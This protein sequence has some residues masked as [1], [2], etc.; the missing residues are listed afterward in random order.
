MAVAV[1]VVPG[2][3]AAKDHCRKILLTGNAGINPKPVIFYVKNNLGDTTLSE[4]CPVTAQINEADIAYIKR[5]PYAWGTGPAACPPELQPGELPYDPADPLKSRCIDYAG[6]SCR[7]KSKVAPKTT[8]A[9]KKYTEI[10]CFEEP[11]CGVKLG[12]SSPTPIP[13]TIQVEKLGSGV[14][15][16]DPNDCDDCDTCVVDPDP[17]GARQ[18]P[19]PAGARCRAGLA[20]AVNSYIVGT[21]QLLVD[22]H[23][24]RMAGKR[25]PA[26][27]CNTTNADSEI[28]TAVNALADGI[29]SAAGACTAARSPAT[30]GFR[31]CPVPCSGIGAAAC[32][33]GQV[34]LQCQ[35][36]R[37]C[38]VT[39][40]AGD[41][42]CGDWAQATDCIACL[43][44]NA[45]TTAVQDKYGF[46]SVTLPPASQKCQNLIGSALVRLAAARID[47]TLDCQ[48]RLDGGKGSIDQL[49]MDQDPKETL[50][51]AES[52]V[53]SA[54]NAACDPTSL[55]ALDSV[56]GGATTLSG[57]AQCIVTNARQLNKTFSH[58]VFPSSTKVC[59][60][61][62]RQNIEQCDGTDDASC[63]GQCTA[64]C[65]C[66]TP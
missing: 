56:C 25:P 15:C 4:S 2:A 61:N 51:I 14:L 16:P 1:A 36:D 19:S 47:A 37:D 32:T 60:D 6:G 55:A 31:A 22:C 46:P 57:I 66:P 64:Q 39:P 13:I 12:T 54:V 26:T 49:C 65:L 42:R 3:D 43:A 7:I 11:S 62:T 20:S 29:V 33:A 45:V 52:Q 30:L 44:A 38:D 27:D 50:A 9:S 34:G 8:G 63:P 53:A 59:G 40:G 58:I 18:T 41:G 23:K 21:T 24:D 17:I 5:L 28:L 48:K 10:C 35:S